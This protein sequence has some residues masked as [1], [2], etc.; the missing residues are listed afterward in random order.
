LR[1]AKVKI[2]NQPTDALGLPETIWTL[3]RSKNGTSIIHLINL[4]GSRDPHWRDVEMTRPEPPL[5]QDL[6]L[7]I[8]GALEVRAAGWASPDVDSGKFRPLHFEKKHLNGVAVI[9]LTIPTLCY[10]DTIFLS[11]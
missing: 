11:R 5:L 2:A 4:L 6:R 7:E 1:C 10:W 3:A 9:Q 8:V